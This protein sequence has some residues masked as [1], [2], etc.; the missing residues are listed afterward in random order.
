[1]VVHALWI[2]T[3]LSVMDVLFSQRTVFVFSEFGLGVVIACS[4][5]RRG[6]SAW[7][8]LDPPAVEQTLRQPAVFSRSELVQ[9]FVSSLTSYPSSKTFVGLLRSE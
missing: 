1:M 7:K 4:A 9:L 6:E 2:I 3:A 5:V 8:L